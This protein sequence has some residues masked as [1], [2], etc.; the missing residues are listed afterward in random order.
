MSLAPK[1]LRRRGWPSLQATSETQ[2]GRFSIPPVA[3]HC[4][5]GP[6]RV[7]RCRGDVVAGFLACLAAALDAGLGTHDASDVR[8]ACLAGEAAVAGQPI[9]LPHD[10]H[11]ALRDAAMSLVMGGAGVGCAGRGCCEAGLGARGGFALTASRWPAPRMAW[12]MAALVAMAPI[13]T[14]ASRRPPC[15]ASRASRAG[16]AVN[17]L[18]LP[19]TASCPGTRQAVVAKAETR[20]IGSVPAAWSWLRRDVLPSVAAKP[21]QARWRAPRP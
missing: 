20:W 6:R 10:A 13:E 17:S 11:G 2:C 18:A 8:Q 19:G 5:A 14:S 4:L 9:D 1:P 3:V 21:R 12:A 16:M 7:K 15:S